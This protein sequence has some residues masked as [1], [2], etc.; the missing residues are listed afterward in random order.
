MH[1]LAED[2]QQHSILEW[3]KQ[4][5]KQN[6]LNIIGGSIAVKEEDKL[7]NRC[8]VVNREGEVIYHYDKT[9]LFS[10]GAE[11]KHFTPGQ[12]S[13]RIFEL[14]GTPCSTIICYDIRFPELI[15]KK[16][17]LG[18]RILFVPAQWPHPRKD[19][20]V[21]LGKARA[22]ENQMIV[23]AVNGCGEGAGL[24][25]CGHSAIYNAWGESLVSAEEEEG[26]FWAE[27]DLEQVNEV[28]AKIPVFNDRRIDLY[29]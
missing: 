9:H 3:M 8:Y 12:Q 29:F 22:I 14:D 15:R 26:L 6:N 25:S 11:Q 4:A 17:L 5:A 23:V 2:V 16:A 7:F 18:A 20:W 24:K 21:T 13:N 27:V 19:H 10:P 1:E 28:R